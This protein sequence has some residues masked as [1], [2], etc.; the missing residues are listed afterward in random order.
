MAK[1]ADKII[2]SNKEVEVSAVTIGGRDGQVNVAEFYVHLV[3]FKE[4]GVSTT[5]VKE[6]LR[7]QLKV[8]AAANPMI[9][10]T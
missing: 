2:R 7:G 10:A 8:L 6:R 5:V 4:R 9:A 3:K 1:E